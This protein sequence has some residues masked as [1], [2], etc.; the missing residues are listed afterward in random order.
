MAR[1]KKERKLNMSDYEPSQYQKDIFEF[2]SHGVGNLV[3]EAAAGSGKTWTLCKCMELIPDTS[4]VLFCAFNV[5][6]VDE[7]KVKLKD[8]K[9]V[10]VSTLH[11][12][13][14]TLLIRNF[15]K[16][17][18]YETCDFK[19]NS[20]IARNLKSLSTMG[21]MSAGN[22]TL[23]RRNVNKLVDYGRLYLVDNVKDMY[24]VADRYRIEMVGD[25]AE[26]ALKVMEWGKGVLD[27]ID[28]TDMI[29]LP[30]ALNIGSSGLRYDYIFVDE[31]QDLSIAQ[32]SILMK[33]VKINTRIVAAG[34]EDQTIYSFNG[35]DPESF[36]E[37]KSLPNTVS[38]PLSISYRCADDIVDY[39]SKYGVIEK[40]GNGVK[41]EVEQGSRI[42]SIEDG[43]MVLCR[44]N[45]PL[46]HVY[47]KLV[48]EG[49]KCKIL[50]KSFSSAV[51]P[52]ISDMGMTM[53]NVSLMSDGLFIRLY[54]DLLDEMY[55]LM[56]N[57]SI[58]MD[59]AFKS[60]QIQDKFDKIKSLEVLSHGLSTVDQLLERID[61]I[62]H[63]GG[64]ELEKGTI[65]L[66]TIHKSKG[67]EEDV[68]YI[69][70]N[71]LMPSPYA[72]RDWEKR[73][74]QCLMYVAYTRPKKKLSFLSDDEFHDFDEKMDFLKLLKAEAKVNEVLNRKRRMVI[75]T[76][77]TSEAIVKSAKRIVDPTKKA[78]ITIKN[79]PSASTNSFSSILKKKAKKIFRRNG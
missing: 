30:N 65:R 13:G 61:S 29:W 21:S 42:S 12:M 46:M 77:E 55:L 56:D 51:K 37:F 24:E 48:S 47:S 64:D 73:Q 53:L 32:R 74:E 63:E 38:L 66:S 15:G 52:W 44:N 7:L 43:S 71:S 69:A 50:G 28:Y 35:A 20:Y 16:E 54:A 6:I 22:Y 41:G 9:N 72:I 70:R 26:V 25:E 27:E 19:Y 23:Y 68:V 49:K 57:Y 78:P 34:C 1:K 10:S 31:A 3:I 5:D 62:V 36:N 11:K 14:R 60:T 79:G 76:P 2:I 75:A 67:L 39:A 33:M 40:N 8:F 4:K 45:A 59:E 17:Y 58:D 18:K